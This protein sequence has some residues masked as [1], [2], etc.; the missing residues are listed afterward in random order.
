MAGTDS[1]IFLCEHREDFGSVTKEM[2]TAFF[3]SDF[4]GMYPH[5]DYMYYSEELAS[6][7][8]PGCW[9]R[10]EPYLVARRRDAKPLYRNTMAD[11]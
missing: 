1:N 2:Y 8:P 5:L 3:Y 6:K 7:R 9:P 11:F 10:F 4:F